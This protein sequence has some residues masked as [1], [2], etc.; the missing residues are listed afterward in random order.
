[1]KV[2]LLLSFA[3]VCYFLFATLAFFLAPAHAEGTIRAWQSLQNYGN[4]DLF[5]ELRLI[6]KLDH[7]LIGSDIIR[8]RL[9]FSIGDLREYPKLTWNDFSELTC[10]FDYLPNSLTAIQVDYHNDEAIYEYTLAF[11]S[12]SAVAIASSNVRMKKQSWFL[13]RI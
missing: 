10:V 5:T 4:R 2:P 11:Q 13:L 1:M 3:S 12:T 9:P 6:F 7:S 8:L